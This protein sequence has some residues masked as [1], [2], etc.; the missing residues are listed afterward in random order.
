[1]EK[2]ITLDPI[3]SCIFYYIYYIYIYSNIADSDTISIISRW[4]LYIQRSLPIT[5]VSLIIRLQRTSYIKTLI[6]YQRVRRVHLPLPFSITFH[7]VL[8]SFTILCFVLA[9]LLLFC[10]FYLRR[11]QTI[12]GSSDFPR[13]AKSM[14]NEELIKLQDQ[15]HHDR[16]V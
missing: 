14:A 6:E 11:S 9:S 7:L 13:S 8:L 1:M 15:Q 10:S 4:I 12:F 2:K 16:Y 3:I 5:P